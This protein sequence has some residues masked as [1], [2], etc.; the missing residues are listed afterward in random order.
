[1]D[2]IKYFIPW[3]KEGIAVSRIPKRYLETS[4][5]RRRYCSLKTYITIK[6]QYETVLNTH[7]KG[8]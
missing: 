4:K 7:R 6:K 1:M 5:I 8:L 3:L 2:Y